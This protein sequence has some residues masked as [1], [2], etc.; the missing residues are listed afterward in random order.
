M[1]TGRLA[2]GVTLDQAAAEM[3]TVASTLAREHPETHRGRDVLTLQAS[4]AM[5]GPNA[6]LAMTLLIGTAALVMVIASVNV[7]GVLLARAVSRQR[8][9]GLR[10]ALG[11]GA[12]RVFRQL[13]TE[14]ALLAVVSAVGGVVVAVIGL[15]L[16]DTESKP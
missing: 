3:R 6:V 1:A 4:R 11:A 13:L 16:F 2:D 8:E 10:M 12:A 15:R 5:G 14:G 9:F 7:S